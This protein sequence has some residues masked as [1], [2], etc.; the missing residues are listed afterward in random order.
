M[1][2][3]RRRENERRRKVGGDVLN[4]LRVEEG[5]IRPYTLRSERD[6]LLNRGRKKRVMSYSR[7]LC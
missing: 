7:D 5:G 3:E 1:E 4:L 6:F 2:G